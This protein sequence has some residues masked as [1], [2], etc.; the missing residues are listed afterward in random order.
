M[1]R[2]TTHFYAEKF[3]TKREFI[4][5]IHNLESRLSSKLERQKNELKIDFAKITK[6][7]FEKAKEKL[8][9]KKKIPEI[10]FGLE[11]T[12]EGWI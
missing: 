8:E 4:A 10:Y 7:E 5:R 2:R 6:L 12:K 1:N 3:L 11:S 9:E